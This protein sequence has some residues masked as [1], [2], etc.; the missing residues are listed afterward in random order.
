MTRRT[1]KL[2]YD[3]EAGDAGGFVTMNVAKAASINTSKDMQFLYIERKPGKDGF[4]VNWST[5][6]IPE[7][8]K[9]KDITMERED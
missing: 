3:N 1:L 8:M 6:L 5:N 4:T 2:R 9:I 7:G